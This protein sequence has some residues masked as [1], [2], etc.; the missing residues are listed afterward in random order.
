MARR[1]K[2]GLSGKAG[3]AGTAGTAAIEF[4]LVLPMLL[5]LLLG[6]VEVGFLIL[7]HASMN[8]TMARVPDLVRR[9]ASVD[10]L[11]AR[12]ATLADL[13]L[14][15]GLAV[16]AFDPVV[17]TCVCPENAARFLDDAAARPRPCPIVCA[18]GADAVRL[19][20]VTGRVTVPSLIPDNDA[21]L[22]RAIARL[23]VMGP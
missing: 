20:A 3:T 4:A 14:G 11:D 9:A 15:L 17:E 2:S 6:A 19:Y 8:A 16:V 1:R 10:D 5:I 22:R 13:P 23:T 18:A 12:L 21:G 7:S